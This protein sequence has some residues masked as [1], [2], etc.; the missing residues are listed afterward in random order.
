M[1]HPSGPNVTIS[2]AGETPLGVSHGLGHQT[3]G[4]A[5]E[6]IGQGAVL[7]KLCGRVSQLSDYSLFR[8]QGYDRGSCSSV[9]VRDRNG[10]PRAP[11]V[12]QERSRCVATDSTAGTTQPSHSPFLET[13][14]TGRPDQSNEAEIRLFD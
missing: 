2:L 5:V 1:I 12:P 10:D 3:D 8:F 4:S 6:R 14:E 9:G 7:D 11:I 13:N